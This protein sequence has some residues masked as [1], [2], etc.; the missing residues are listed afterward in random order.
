MAA[1]LAA[2]IRFKAI[3]PEASTMKMISDPA[4]RAMR[5]AR[6]SEPSM[7]TPRVSLSVPCQETNVV[8]FDRCTLKY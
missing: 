1:P 7:K 5:L 4:F 6:T 3:D 8:W 2:F